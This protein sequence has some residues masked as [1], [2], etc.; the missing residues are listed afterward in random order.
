MNVE[1]V[2]DSI[3]RNWAHGVEIAKSLIA[4]KSTSPDGDGISECAELVRQ[5][6]EEHGASAR[7]IKTS[8]NPYVLGELKARD[9]SAPTVILL[10]HYDV[11]PIGNLPAWNTEPFSPTV[12]DGVLY[13]RGAADNK[14]QFA[15]NLTGVKAWIDT[16]GEVPVNVKFLLEGEEEIGSPTFEEFVQANRD[17]LM[18]DV[19]FFADAAIHE[20]GAPN[21]F[22]GVRGT[23]G[24]KLS[25]TTAK[26]NHHSGNKGGVIPEAAW[27]LIEVIAS[28]RDEDGTVIIDGFY[29]DIVSPTDLDWA[30]IDGI[31]YDPAAIKR[32]YG[33]KKDLQLSKRDYYYRLM[34]L[35]TL[36]ICG[37]HAGSVPEQAFL[38][39]IPG[40]AEAII[41]IRFPLA[42]T[43]EKLFELVSKHVASINPEVKVEYIASGKASRSPTDLPVLRAI[44]HAVEKIY[45]RPAVQMPSLGSSWGAEHLFTQVLDIPCIY[46]PCANTDENNHGPNENLRLDC[47]KRGAHVTAE[48]LDALSTYKQ[49]EA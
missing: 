12:K 18:G 26:M 44:S 24:I 2:H 31:P 43:P 46:V 41:N 10:N 34:F 38:P 28:M 11:Q 9:P 23:L 4:Q 16:Y 49:S 25:I 47:F 14:G 48:V 32:E 39:I 35:P 20:S 3:E 42:Q 13:G 8:G 27:Q 36:S 1:T 22:Y 40:Q 45:K 7:I 30:M 17:L 15:A 37:I 5:I 21:I 6:L 29:N 33:L 19:V